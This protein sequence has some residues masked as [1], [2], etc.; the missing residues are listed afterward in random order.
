MVGASA[1]HVDELIQE[2]RDED[3]DLVR[4]SADAGAGGGRERSE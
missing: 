4:E 1:D 2:V 3:Y